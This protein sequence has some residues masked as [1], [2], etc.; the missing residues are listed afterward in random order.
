MG[1]TISSIL[2]KLSSGH[3]NVCVLNMAFFIAM[4]VCSFA[5]FFFYKRT[6]NY[7]GSYLCAFTSLQL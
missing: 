4:V 6:G 3:I 7:G 5:F 1:N 2:A